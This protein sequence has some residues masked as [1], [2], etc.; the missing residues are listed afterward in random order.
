MSKDNNDEGWNLATA[1]AYDG[2]DDEFGDTT[3]RPNPDGK[4]KAIDGVTIAVDKKLIPYSSYVEIMF[5]DGTIKRM[6]AHDTGSA[7]VKRT[8]SIGRGNLDKD[9]NPLP[10]IDV[11]HAAGNLNAYNEEIG[12]IVKWRLIHV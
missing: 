1:T 7:V 5:K 10:V 2:L 9:G 8:A 12:N 4:F 11:Y 6:Y 3:A